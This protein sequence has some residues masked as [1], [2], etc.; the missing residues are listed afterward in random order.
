MKISISKSDLVTALDTVIK[1]TSS[2]TTV[3]SLAGILIT[4]NQDKI[5]FFASDLETSIKTSVSGIIDEPGVLAVPGKLFSNIIKNLPEAVVVIEALDNQAE[6]TCNQSHFSIRTLNPD[7]FRRFPDITGI[8]S[9]S[10]PVSVLDEMVKKTVKATSSVELNAILTGILLT[11]D[12]EKITMVAT[13]GHR[14]ALV[15]KTLENPIENK[16]EVLVPG[17]AFDE[18]VKMAPSNSEISLTLTSNQILFQFGETSFVTRRIEGN[19][20]N[21]KALIPNEWKS[22]TTL[23]LAEF[24]EAVKR[25]SLMALLNTAIKISCSLEDQ[26]ISISSH[27]Q[28]F[29][30]ANE[31]VLAKV[32]G[33]SQD[34]SFNYSYIQDALSV[35][36]SDFVSLEIVNNLKPGLLRCPEEGFIYILM[37]VKFNN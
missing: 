29:G 21:Y 16:F 18:I 1:A 11:I 3:P 37:P 19:F 2:R 22:R 10:L 30:D 5:T 31:T 14:L 15:E 9:I 23:S 24:N 17:K 26:Q 27:S 13:D 6:I 28:D 36:K 34:I 33:E 25:V 35:I 32:E 4:T 8:D 7:D 20:P 12:K